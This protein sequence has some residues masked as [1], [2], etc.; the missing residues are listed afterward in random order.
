MSPA[1]GGREY[2]Q[3]R[4]IAADAV[5]WGL[6]LVLSD[7]VARA[8]PANGR[9]Y[10]LPANARALAPGL[11]ATHGDMWSCSAILD[12]SGGPAV[13]TLPNAHGAYLTLMLHDGWGRILAT[14]G[15]QEHRLRERAIAVV[16]PSWTGAIHRD[17]TEVR[18]PGDWVWAVCHILGAGEG[19]REDA[20]RLREMIALRSND[21]F[22]TALS[23]APLDL[24]PQR[25]FDDV[26]EMMA[27][28]TFFWRLARLTATHPPHSDDQAMVAALRRIGVVPGQHFS[29]R[30]WPADRVHAIDEGFEEGLRRVRWATPRFA[31]LGEAGWTISSAGVR[32]RCEALERSASVLTGFGAPPSDEVLVFTTTSDE[33]GQP[34]SG[35]H[36]YCLTFEA[37]DAP[38]AGAFW[39]ICVV[40]RRGAPLDA[41]FAR[42]SVGDW[43]GLTPT[44]G[45]R[46]ETSIQLGVE[47][48]GGQRLQPPPGPFGL[49]LELYRPKRLAL[50]QT[51][52]PPAVVNNGP[53]A[54]RTNVSFAAARFAASAACAPRVAVGPAIVHFLR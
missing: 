18:A 34:L 11:L 3:M 37:D 35:D 43:F 16:G 21:G 6:P 25:A 23:S 28:A 29:Y 22:S 19:G 38:P 26:L 17:V 53:C 54:A 20:L 42:L 44:P 24:A 46:F 32:H 47:T 36:D 9:F 31:G 50:G 8:H 7:L 51:W 1:F 49:R 52:R 40:D 13:I 48:G 45:E 14:L 41:P 30:D 10:E 4:R 12:V 39:S 33:Q 27:P 15:P 5:V 2:A